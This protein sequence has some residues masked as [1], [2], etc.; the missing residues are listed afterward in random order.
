MKSEAWKYDA[1]FKP[2]GIWYGDFDSREKAEAYVRSSFLKQTGLDQA[3]TIHRYKGYIEIFFGRNGT[4]TDLVAEYPGSSYFAQKLEDAVAE[5]GCAGFNTCVILKC[6]APLDR[7]QKYHSRKLKHIGFFRTLHG[8][9]SVAEKSGGSLTKHKGQLSIWACNFPNLRSLKAYFKWPNTHAMPSSPF[10]SENR[11]GFHFDEELCEL[12]HSENGKPVDVKTLLH[13]Q[14]KV[15]RLKPAEEAGVIKLFEGHGISETQG[16]FVASG[17][18]HA[19]LAKAGGFSG[20]VENE[21]CQFLGS[22]KPKGKKK[23]TRKK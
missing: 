4:A 15:S 12:L 9:L 6:H 18:N 13:S 5:E 10:Y 14:P 2:I 8:S 21:K 16:I 20:R 7:E 11:P 3:K 22:F 23:A 17:Y 1:L 19:E